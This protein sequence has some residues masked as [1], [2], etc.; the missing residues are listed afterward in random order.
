M[1]VSTKSRDSLA[2]NGVRCEM[3]ERPADLIVAV[4]RPHPV[5]VAID[6]RG[7]AGKSTLADNLVRGLDQEPLVDVHRSDHS[8]GRGR[9]RWP[10]RYSGS[11]ASFR[12][13]RRSGSRSGRIANAPSSRDARA[14]AGSSE[15]TP[16][17]TRPCRR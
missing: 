13:S 17:Q 11:S 4:E 7:G 14:G 15:P 5:G 10:A 2:E 8:T 16:G 12:R 6:G 1:S 9:S 3:L